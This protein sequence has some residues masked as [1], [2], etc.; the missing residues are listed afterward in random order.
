M[1][2]YLVYL[3]MKKQILNQILYYADK[4][5]NTQG[6]SIY[7]IKNLSL[8]DKSIQRLRKKLIIVSME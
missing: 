7:D 8:W 6:L 1:N 4:T 5:A 3:T 2:Y